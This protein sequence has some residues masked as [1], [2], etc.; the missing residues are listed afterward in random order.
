MKRPPASL[1]NSR[2][3]SQPQWF[4]VPPLQDSVWPQGLC[5]APPAQKALP[6]AL[7]P[8]AFKAQFCHHLLQEASP[9]PYP[10]SKP[11]ERPPVGSLS[12][13]GFLRWWLLRCRLV[14]VCCSPSSPTRL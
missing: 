12:L 1:W 13:L 3:L 6:L 10:S 7:P 2:L 11:G 4:T 14:P 8:P 5:E 9:F